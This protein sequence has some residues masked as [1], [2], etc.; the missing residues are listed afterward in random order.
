MGTF[1]MSTDTDG[2]CLGYLPAIHWMG[3]RDRWTSSYKGSRTV[4]GGETPRYGSVYA[5]PEAAPYVS[6]ASSISPP[7]GRGPS[8]PLPG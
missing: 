5:R 8:Q 2:I 6:T 7:L 3:I 4:R 1:E